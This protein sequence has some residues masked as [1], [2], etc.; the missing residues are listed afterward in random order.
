MVVKGF[1]LCCCSCCRRRLEELQR[2]GVR[3]REEAE[4]LQREV[5]TV[6]YLTPETLSEASTEGSSSPQNSR[7][8]QEVLDLSTRNLELS[9]SNAEL[10]AR[11][12]DH[13][14]AVQTLEERLEEELSTQRDQVPARTTFSNF[15]PDFLLHFLFLSLCCSLAVCQRWRR[16]L[17]A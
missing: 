11:L 14:G 8:R 17:T 3:S 6:K 10:S 5:T 1:C 7:H 2:E 13:Q 4:L 12:H 16:S 9:S 15:L